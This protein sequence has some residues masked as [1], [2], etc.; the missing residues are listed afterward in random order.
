MG[1][2]VVTVPSRASLGP[3]SQSRTHADRTAVFRVPAP[4][5]GHLR[6]S[7]LSEDQEDR[8]DLADSGHFSNE[9]MTKFLGKLE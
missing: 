3:S 9:K 7:A 5:T 2:G 8:Q 1:E 4:F 6:P